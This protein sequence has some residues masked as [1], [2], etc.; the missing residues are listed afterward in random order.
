MYKF[1]ICCARTKH[2]SEMHISRTVKICITKPIRIGLERVKCQ[3][4]GKIWLKRLLW[5]HFETNDTV[6]VS[7]AVPSAKCFDHSRS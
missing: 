3:K 6:E 7:L 5:L 1:E 4:F 2:L